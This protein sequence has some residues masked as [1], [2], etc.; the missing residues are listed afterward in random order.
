MK[1]KTKRTRRTD[2]T[3]PSGLMTI[4][5]YSEI[6]KPE[7]YKGKFS[8]IPTPFT[9]EQI[10]TI[11]APTPRNVIRKRPGADGKVFDYVP[12][13]WIK[14]KLN[15]LFGFAYDF[16]ILG[17]RVD[18]DFITVK[19]RLVIRD[20]KTGKEIAVKD[21]YGGAKIKFY[22]GTKN[23][24]DISN[25]FKA[26]QTDCLKRCA[27]QLGLCSDVYGKEEMELEGEKVIDDI[28]PTIPKGSEGE[29]IGIQE[30]TSQIQK[31]LEELGYKTN[32]SKLRQIQRFAEK[33]GFK[34]DGWRMTRSQARK[35]LAKLLQVKLQQKK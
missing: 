24:V 19:G 17:E 13:W 5:P 31:V 9:E 12:G 3:A 8:L 29:E 35:L 33:E 1:K 34:F 16:Q 18:G 27:V 6:V 14:K 15:F 2:S 4:V 7:M 10:K 32:D 11:I 23:P 28:E 25:A 20:P 21:D 26:A 30:E 22:K